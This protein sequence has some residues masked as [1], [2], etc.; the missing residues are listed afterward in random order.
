MNTSKFIK[1]VSVGIAALTA[2]SAAFALGLNESGPAVVA[3]ASTHIDTALVRAGY[4]M[5]DQAE[6]ASTVL[7]ALAAMAVIVKR[8]G[9]GY[10]A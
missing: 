6:V 9:K 8:R 1:R 5:H 10:D 4:F 3:F 7:A 2:I